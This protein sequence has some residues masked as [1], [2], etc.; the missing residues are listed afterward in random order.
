[1][2]NLSF[3]NGSHCPVCQSRIKTF[4]MSTHYSFVCPQCSSTLH[5]ANSYRRVL[6]IAMVVIA[7]LLTYAISYSVDSFIII[8]LIVVFLGGGPI[9]ILI[10]WLVPPKL[11]E[12]DAPD[13]IIRISL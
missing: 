1:M 7:L 8:G 4:A 3:A 12:G 6:H 13:H 5:I 2:P 10:T 9:L 11:I